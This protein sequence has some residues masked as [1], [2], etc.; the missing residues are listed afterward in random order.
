MLTN[1]QGQ[2]VVTCD[3]WHLETDIFDNSY[4]V[5]FQFDFVPYGLFGRLIV[6]LMYLM[7]AIMYWQTG[8][9][10]NGD[11][12]INEI[13]NPINHIT[14]QRFSW[15]ALIF[16]NLIWI[17]FYFFAVLLKFWCGF[18]QLI[19]QFRSQTEQHLFQKLNFWCQ[20][21]TFLTL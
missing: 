15:R 2:L 18:T 21:L 14:S 12:T 5:S 16:L 11:K 1:F 13:S 20:Q 10:L 3:M 19:V 4:Y 6:R 8:I 7:P 17:F 9:L